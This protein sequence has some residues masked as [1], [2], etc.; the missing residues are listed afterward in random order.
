MLVLEE[1]RPCPSSLQLLDNYLGDT[2]EAATFT[3]MHNAI[4]ITLRRGTCSREGDDI[5]ASRRIFP[6]MG[7]ERP[8]AC[9]QTR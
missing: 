1:H 8:V 5:I 7:Q 6:K 2:Q 9:A 4:L 3:I